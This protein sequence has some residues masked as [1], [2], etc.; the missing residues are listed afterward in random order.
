MSAYIIF[1][2]V[3]VFLARV[4]DVSLGTL[5]TI[6]I[7]NGRSRIA[8][9]LGL[10]EVSIWLV[11]ISTVVERM[12]EAPVLG[13]FYAV[14][15]AMGNVVGIFIEKRLA[16]GFVA[17]RAI[18]MREDG[19]AMAE[20]LRSL[21]HS[22]TVFTGEGMKGPVIEIFIASS[23]REFGSIVATLEKMDPEIFY[24]SEQA[25]VLSG[26]RTPLRRTPAGLRAILKRK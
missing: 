12:H 4:V 2:G 26:Y 6:S 18:T 17:I 21:G 20:R 14:G 9:L 24:V 3:L 22:V 19:R 23:R 13:L 16:M 7:V 11:V 1:T 25:N 15:F 10:V 8:F 5:R